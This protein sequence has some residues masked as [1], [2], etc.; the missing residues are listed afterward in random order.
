[1]SYAL[2][3]YVGE[4]CTTSFFRLKRS[5][6]GFKL[7]ESYESAYVSH[8]NQIELAQHDL[9]PRVYSQVGRVRTD[10]NT[11]SNWGYITEIAKTIVCPGNECECCDRDGLYEDMEDEIEE[12]RN[13][14]EELGF[15]WPDD[16]AGNVGYVRRNSTD[17]LVC[18]DTGDESLQSDDGPCFCLECKKGRNCR[19]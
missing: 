6:R 18:I 12:L 5:R 19:G 16:H 15:Y 1:M 3:R 9:A 7:F 11:L 8:Y 17:I 10:W 4:G 14:I 13:K 2:D